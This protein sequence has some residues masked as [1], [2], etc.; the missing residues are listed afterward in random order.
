[1]RRTQTTVELPSGGSLAIGGL[2]QQETKQNLDA[3]PGVK[4]LPVLGAL[5]R[6][7]DFQNNESELVVTVTAYLVSPV[8][9]ALIAGPDDGY[10]TP[11]DLET[12]LLGRLNAQYGKDPQTKP[13]IAKDNP[14]Y[15]LQ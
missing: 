14:G 5:F 7:R 12:I 9:P 10:A 2:I 8:A 6:S 3:L 15:V 1:V 11:T 4:D 13:A